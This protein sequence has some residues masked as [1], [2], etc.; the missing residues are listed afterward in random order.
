MKYPVIKQAQFDEKPSRHNEENRYDN[1]EVPYS[2]ART[3]GRMPQDDGIVHWHEA[4]QLICM[5]SGEKEIMFAD[6]SVK[7]TA[8]QGIFI[9]SH[10]LHAGRESTSDYISVRFDPA[11][12]GSTPYL[13]EKYTEPLVHSTNAHIVLDP[14]VF[15]QNTI[16]EMIQRVYMF[17][18]AEAD[19]MPLL[20]EHM[21]YGIWHELYENLPRSLPAEPESHDEETMKKMLA[22]IDENYGNFITLRDI[23]DAGNLSPSACSALFRKKTQKPPGRYLMDYRLQM[24]K[25]L[26][27]K[28]DYP[29][30]EVAL[31]CGFTDT[32][33]F[34]SMFKRSFSV[35]PLAYRKLVRS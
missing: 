15:W 5:I 21:F 16:L 32:S 31:L 9:N 23:A 17:S 14:D 25:V 13:R 19:D 33:H 1:P 12:V 34:I 28:T 30:T 10:I 7:L 3:W 27:Y 35:T 29:V 4:V 11:M 2:V 24:A 6:G 20:A 26:L 8:G 22:F 18:C